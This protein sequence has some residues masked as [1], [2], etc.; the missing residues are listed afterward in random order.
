MT[1][2]FHVASACS[3]GFKVTVNLFWLNLLQRLLFKIP[4]EVKASA[5]E[6]F[7]CPVNLRDNNNGKITLVVNVSF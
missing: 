2:V 4:Y 1:I 5:A 6:I 7:V 3:S